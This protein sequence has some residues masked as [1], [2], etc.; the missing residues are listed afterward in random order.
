MIRDKD[1]PANQVTSDRVPHKH[2]L[3]GN[4]TT[5]NLSRTFN[6]F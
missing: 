1:R 3:V 5:V 6:E 2:V 4:N